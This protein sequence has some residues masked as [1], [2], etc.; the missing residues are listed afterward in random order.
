[1]ARKMV[2][3]LVNHLSYKVLGPSLTIFLEHKDLM[4]NFAELNTSFPKL[5]EK[6]FTANFLIIHISIQAANNLKI[7]K[8]KI[9]VK[10]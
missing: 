1:M 8:I 5:F 10:G 4:G 3:N 9:N 6:M 2:K 7:L